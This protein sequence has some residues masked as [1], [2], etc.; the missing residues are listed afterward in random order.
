MKFFERFKKE[1]NI[2]TDILNQPE[3]VADN[4]TQETGQQTVEEIQDEK[5]VQKDR[6]ISYVIAGVVILVTVAVIW[7]AWRNQ[8]ATAP[9]PPSVPVDNPT[10][11]L[12]NALDKL[13]GKEDIYYRVTGSKRSTFGGNT[14][15]ENYSQLVYLEGVNSPDMKGLVEETAQ[16]GDHTIRSIEVFLGGTGYFTTANAKY[17][18]PIEKDA[19]LA[20]YAPLQLVDPTLY[21]DITGTV[22]SGEKTVTLRTPS[23]PEKWIADTGITMLSVE[24]QVALNNRNELV[25]TTYT[26]TYEKDGMTIYLSLKAEPLDWAAPAFPTIVAKDF[27]QVSDLNIPKTLERSIGYLTSATSI[28]AEYNEHIYVEAFGDDRTKSIRMTVSQESN[29]WSAQIRT[30]TTPSNSSKPGAMSPTKTDEK[31][32]GGVYTYSIND[33]EYVASENITQEIIDGLNARHA[34]Y[35]KKK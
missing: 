12:N 10:A 26:I 8:K 21:S 17:Q 23:A 34:K 24:A 29:G 4:D 16:I 25:S 6:I 27:I 14:Y 2:S 9:V 20:R 15:Q 19:Y 7:G 5:A 35:G 18:A 33:S 28:H 30:V 22:S 31:F 3:T 13:S 11:A 32:T 1:K